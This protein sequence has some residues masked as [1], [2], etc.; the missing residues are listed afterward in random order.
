ML[1]LDKK[2]ALTVCLML[3]GPILT[4]FVRPTT[5]TSYVSNNTSVADMFP[6]EFAGWREINVSSLVKPKGDYRANDSIYDQELYRVYQN[7]DGDR[8]MMVIAFGHN[9]SDALQLHRPEVC[10]RANGFAVSDVTAVN[11]TP[12]VKGHALDIP[13]TQLMSQRVRR[14]EPITYW[15]RVGSGIPS[16]VVTLQLE[17]LWTG[18]SGVIPDGALVRI[19]SI[20]SDKTR[21]FAL[22][23]SFITDLIGATGPEGLAM[24]LG[25]RSEIFS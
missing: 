14:A 21:E 5:L 16:G 17:K 2:L 8:V 1:K 22:H 23:Q 15:T 6:T 12:T 11:L 18:L 7:E 20:G 9:Q 24:L 25:N 3:L 19:S 13:A 4:E 10:Y